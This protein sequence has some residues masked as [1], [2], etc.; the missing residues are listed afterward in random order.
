SGPAPPAE[1]W[2][3]GLRRRTGRAVA[4]RRDVAF[5][6]GGPQ[7][8]QSN[9]PQTPPPGPRLKASL[10]R[11]GLGLEPDYLT[12][13]GSGA[14]IGDIEDKLRRTPVMVIVVP[15]HGSHR[16]SRLETWRPAADHRSGAVGRTRRR[17]SPVRVRESRR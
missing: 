15:R 8:G 6:I 2:D 11:E 14:L 5:R 10:R 12:D 17:P 3:S 7:A 1:P 13:T 4:R 9:R 16:R